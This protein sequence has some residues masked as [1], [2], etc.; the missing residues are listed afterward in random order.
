M[1]DI[2]DPRNHDLQYEAG[3]FVLWVLENANEDVVAC[4]AKRI[5]DG[6]IYALKLLPVAAPTPSPPIRRI[7]Y[8]AVGQIAEVRWLARADTCNCF[9]VDVGLVCALTQ[10]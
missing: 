8:K 4:V 3:K 5:L 2:I 10:N 1:E 7:L 6:A 9:L